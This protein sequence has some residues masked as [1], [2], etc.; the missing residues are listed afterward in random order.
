MTAPCPEG[1]PVPAGAWATIEP[2]LRGLVLELRGE[3]RQTLGAALDEVGVDFA[4]LAGDRDRLSAEL[5]EARRLLRRVVEW[6]D[7][8]GISSSLFVALEPTL[9]EALALL[10][11]KASGEAA[12]VSVP[13]R[14]VA[15][16]TT[17]EP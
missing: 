14:P 13:D 15:P 17:E 16:S 11:V 10:S 12:P 4:R 9:N 8:C 7:G 1:D 2:R 6:Y 3:A 5:A